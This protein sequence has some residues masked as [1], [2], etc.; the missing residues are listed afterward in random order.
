MLTLLTIGLLAPPLAVDADLPAG[1]PSATAIRAEIARMMPDDDADPAAGRLRLRLL[2]RGDQLEAQLSLHRPGQPPAAR[3]L[4]GAAS[5]CRALVSAVALSAALISEPLPTVSRPVASLAPSAPPPEVPAVVAP[6]T[7]SRGPDRWAFHAGAHGALGTL[8]GP[9]LLAEVGG[10][11]GE[12]TARI[13]LAGRLHLTLPATVEGGQ[14]SGRIWAGVATGCTAWRQL[15]G[16]LVVVAG[17]QS[18]EGADFATNRTASGLY[19][20]AGGRAAWRW[21]VS[22]SWSIAALG[23]LTTPLSRVTL[24]A[25]GREVW[26]TPPLA[27]HLGIDAGWRF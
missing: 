14:V 12:R 2:A 20:A 6:A 18:L 26:Q 10:A 8:P 13:G 3:V 15:D 27:G 5:D 23:E 17:H 24:T 11:Y 25:S 22:S 16:C 9:G 19:L 4:R 21:A 7:P 1:C